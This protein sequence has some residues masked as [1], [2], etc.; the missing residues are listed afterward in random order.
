MVK[1]VWRTVRWALAAIPVLAILAFVVWAS[2]P[3]RP[4]DEALGALE[5]RSDTQVST[6]RW[7]VFSPAAVEPVAG[8]ILYP[9]ARVDPRAYAPL[10]R[11]I[12]AVGNL[13]VI[14]PMPLNL[15][16]FGG[17][18]AGDV[19][20]AFPQIDH[21]VIGG[22]SLGG[23]FAA[24]YVGRHPEVI[25][26]LVLWAAYPAGSN[27]LSGYGGVVVSVYG[28]ADGLATTDEIRASG[29]LLPAET[30]W[31]PI[32]GGNHAQFG[33]Y[34]EQSGDNEATISRADQQAQIVSATAGALADVQGEGD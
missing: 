18:K 16:F 10:A 5:L 4:M 8:L 23:A 6:D 13:V 12:A 2:T 14:V 24:Q 22:H 15:A 3:L 32:A 28:T 20:A 19:I 21:W 17:E 11:D 29:A 26:G 31:V 25:N 9:G 30:R 34:G 7:L 1:S 33:W 27:D